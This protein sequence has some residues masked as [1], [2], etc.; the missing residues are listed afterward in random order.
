MRGHS[1]L[2]AHRDS[3]RN[4]CRESGPGVALLRLALVSRKDIDRIVLHF[5][6]EFKTVCDI[7]DFVCESNSAQHFVSDESPETSPIDGDSSKI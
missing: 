7:V 1:I 2:I 6:P 3:Q 4:E 5:L